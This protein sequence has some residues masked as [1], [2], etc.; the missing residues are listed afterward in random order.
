VVVVV[1]VVVVASVPVVRVALVVLLSW[2][3]G[4]DWSTPHP[5]IGVLAG[6]DLGHPAS[7]SFEY[8]PFADVERLQRVS[9]TGDVFDSTDEIGSHEG[10]EPVL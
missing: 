1:V 9:I 8:G 3:L 4:A 2:S 10:A 5:E 6:I 7:D